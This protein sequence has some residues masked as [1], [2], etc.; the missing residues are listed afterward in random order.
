MKKILILSFLIL[1]VFS[2][3]VLAQ[4][5]GQ[6]VVRAQASIEKKDYDTALVDLNQAITLQKKN[7]EAFALRGDVYMA[8]KKVELARLD[9]NQAIKLNGKVSAFYYKRGMS[10]R[11]SPGYSR[12]ATMADL[13]KALEIDPK[14]ED[15]LRER[16]FTYYVAEDLTAAVAD[17]QSALKLDSMDAPIYAYLARIHKRTSIDQALADYDTY[18]KIKTDDPYSYVERGQLLE[19][20]NKPEL[21]LPDYNRVIE[22]L[23]KDAIGYS[24]RADLYLRQ[25]KYALG[26]ADLNK[27]I[28]LR[29]GDSSGY[30]R[31]GLVYEVQGKYDIAIDD[32][33]QA[34]KIDAYNSLAK[35]RLPLIIEKFKAVIPFAEER[36]AAF[37]AQ[38]KIYGVKAD[39]FN[40]KSTAFFA[41]DE[42]QQKLAKPDL[43][44]VC[45]KVN[46]LR[47]LFT[48]VTS[49]FVPLRQ[50]YDTEKLAGFTNALNKVEEIGDI[51]ERTNKGVKEYEDY[52]KCQKKTPV[53]FVMF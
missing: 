53:Y 47:S 44:M 51:L 48:D 2:A 29:P 49:A 41:I 12:E 22:L 16:G 14:N 4:D 52:Y 43:K 28:E 34:L 27:T 38:L 33:K 15:A 40:V 1:S 9:Y 3:S 31:R 30:S 46:E 36:S 42:A 21:A 18:L 39:I 19:G 7:A 35:T 24:N 45:G 26:I 37:N 20:Q 17:F 25:K 6:L 5:A 23:P 10:F 32:Y 8:Q 50:M 13:N 11:E